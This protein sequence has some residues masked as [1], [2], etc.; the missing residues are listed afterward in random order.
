MVSCVFLREERKH[1][2]RQTYVGRMPVEAVSTPDWP[3]SLSALSCHHSFKHVYCTHKLDVKQKIFLFP[4]IS[5]LLW[6]WSRWFYFILFRNRDDWTLI[7]K[8]QLHPVSVCLTSVCVCFSFRSHT[9]NS[10]LPTSAKS[11][12]TLNAD[13]R[14]APSSMRWC[15]SVSNTCWRSTSQVRSHLTPHVDKTRSMKLVKLI[16]N[17]ELLMTIWSELLCGFLDV[18]SRVCVLCDWASSHLF[19]YLQAQWSQRR[20]FRKPSSSTRCTSN[21]LCSMKK[22]G[23]KSLRYRKRFQLSV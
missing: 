6:V 15:S 22:A 7:N 18:V 12:P 9:T 10:I 3:V 16:Y 5:S 13:V 19:S 8:L 17:E 20:R 23:G 2:V 1:M 4:Y 11:T 21:R 14:K